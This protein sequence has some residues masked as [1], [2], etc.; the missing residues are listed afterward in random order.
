[1]NAPTTSTATDRRGLLIGALTAGA[2]TTVAAVPT[3][4][5]TTER[6]DPVFALLDAHK[7]AYARFDAITDFDDHEAYERAAGAVDAALD[8]ITNTPPTTVAGMPA[9]M[10]YFVELDGHMDY[11]PTLLR[12]SILR[13]PVLAG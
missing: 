7:Q 13:S 10:E 5:G 9:V 1:M 3:I 4:A 8:E 2:A 12:S 11:L 6:P